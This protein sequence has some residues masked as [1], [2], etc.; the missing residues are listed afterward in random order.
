MKLLQINTN[1]NSGSTGRIAED[2]GKL[3]M[4]MGHESTIAFG[5]GKRPSASQLIRIGGISDFRLHALK[6]RFLDLHGFGSANATRIFL[7]KVNAL[8]PDVIHLHNL[9]GYYLNVEL[10]FNYLKSAHKPVFWTFHDCWPFTGHCSHFD[11]VNCFKWK[12][13]CHHCPN[14]KGYPTSWFLDNSKY[15]YHRKKNLF[16]GIKNLTIVTPSN[17]LAEHVKNS[18]LKDYPVKVIHNGIDLS[19]FQPVEKQEEISKHK[20]FENAYILGVASIW[21]ERKG[22]ADFF[23]LR[24]ML[25]KEIG[26]VLVGLNQ[27][28]ITSLPP[29]ITGIARTENISELAALYRGASVFVNPTYVD[30]FPTTNL[31]ALA[32]GTPVITYNTGGSPE[33]I[34]ENT[35][36]VV[37]KRDVK[38]LAEAIIAISDKGK[39]YYQPLCRDRAEKLFNKEDRFKEYYQLYINNFRRS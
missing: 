20:L 12:T 34:N 21:N 37:E 31:E 13:E 38:G 8:N 18:F 36:L 26:I 1:V 6:T 16:T 23:R 32:C 30:N 24:E 14:K 10:L 28:Q 33:A 39:E 11:G 25:A 9:H 22:L 29:G 4:A 15:N 5:R 19:V 3:V 17:W 2:I 35:G 7:E 27:K